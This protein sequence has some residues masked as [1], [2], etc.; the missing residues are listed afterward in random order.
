MTLWHLV[1]NPWEKHEV[2]KNSEITSK[3]PL[4]PD[5]PEPSAVTPSLRG[6]LPESI[7]GEDG[8]TMR[9]IPGGIL[10]TQPAAG[11]GQAGKVQVDPFY[12]DETKVTFH[13][14]TEFLNSVKDTLTV[15]DG[16]VKRDGEIW[17]LLGE[18]IEEQTEITYQHGR[19]HLRDP[20]KAALPV[21]RVTWYG[22]TAYA[23]HFEERL[24]TE[25]EW[26]FAAQNNRIGNQTDLDKKSKGKQSTGEETGF[27][28]GNVAQEMDQMMKEMMKDTTAPNASGLK[29]MRNDIKE[30]VI[31]I[32]NGQEIGKQTTEAPEQIRY[33]SLVVGK[34]LQTN[35]A[36]L[37]RLTRSFRYPW[38][39]FFDVGFRCVLSAPS[40]N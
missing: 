13:H 6:D 17:F 19:F 2:V 4:V 16:L 9:F 24:P 8:L 15:E 29:D 21:V 31:R 28:S 27:T 11:K 20:K 40:K 26:E 36:T 23:R 38:E 12:L 1:G 39:G 5:L 35:D 3:E 32:R 33:S 14:F 30:W 34:S 7:T 10:N 25:Y 37:L 22:A 18:G